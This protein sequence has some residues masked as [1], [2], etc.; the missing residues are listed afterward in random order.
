MASN[1]RRMNVIYLRFLRHPMEYTDIYNTLISRTARMRFAIAKIVST[2][3]TNGSDG[4]NGD[5]TEYGVRG[6]SRSADKGGGM[7]GGFDNTLWNM[8]FLN[9]HAT[10]YGSGGGGGG[11]DGTIITGSGYQG[12]IYI[13]W[14]KED[15]A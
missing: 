8:D 6:N 7:G 13:R 3:T 12:V 5:T 10:F 2:A 9:Q 15:A 4:G 14:K 1:Q 11:T